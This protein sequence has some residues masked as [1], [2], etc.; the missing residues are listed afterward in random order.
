[1]SAYNVGDIVQ[2][3][4]SFIDVQGKPCNSHT[5]MV[6]RSTPGVYVDENGVKFSFDFSAAIISS[7]CDPLKDPDFRIRHLSYCHNIE[8]LAKD[9]V[10]T[11]PYA[12]NQ[13][14]FIK[15]GQV[16]MFSFKKCRFKSLGY[17][18]EPRK[19]TLMTYLQLIQEQQFKRITDN[20]DKI[21]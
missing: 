18:V 1:M 2:S 21:A 14:G 20:S 4:G 19:I 15:M 3:N 10:M 12:H 9:A 5:F 11:I 6:T 13:D 17:V 8:L 16:Y 7:F